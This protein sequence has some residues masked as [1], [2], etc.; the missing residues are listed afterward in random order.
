[1]TP[2][3]DHASLFVAPPSP[4]GTAAVGRPSSAVDRGAEAMSWLRH[5]F[6]VPGTRHPGRPAEH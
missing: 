1:M 2:N 3:H 6:A 5:P 4:P